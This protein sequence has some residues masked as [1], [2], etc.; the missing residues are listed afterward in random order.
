MPSYIYTHTALLTSP[1]HSWR[2]RSSS[3]AAAADP[4][5]P[6]VDR[7][8]PAPAPAAAAAAAANPASPAA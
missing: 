1:S 4:V 6:A 7:A 2:H 3:N 5:Y 8:P